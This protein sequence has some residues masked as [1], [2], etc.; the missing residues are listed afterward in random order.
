[1][2]DVG[3][4]KVPRVQGTAIYM[5]RTSEGVPPTLLHNLKHNK[6]LHRQIVFLTV[7][8]AEQ[9]H[10]PP[11]ERLDVE[12][13]G[14]GIFR[15]VAL[16]GFMEDAHVP[17]MLGTIQFPGLDFPPN[18]TSFFLGK[19]TIFATKR[20]GMAIWRERIFAVMSRNAR[21]AT[22]FFKL[23]PNRVVELGA[24]IEI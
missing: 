20:P 9:P 19:E 1:M 18:D 10:V 2:A 14:F 22:L 24:Q 21:S 23:P 7:T 12:G 4:G 6:V 3:K 17:E 15:V 5:S 8:T 16:Y 11:A 13:L